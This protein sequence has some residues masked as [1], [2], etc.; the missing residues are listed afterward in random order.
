[1]PLGAPDAEPHKHAHDSAD[2]DSTAVSPPPHDQSDPTHSGAARRPPT[3]PPPPPPPPAPPPR[4]DPGTIP[5]PTPKRA[6]TPTQQP[7]PQRSRASRH[8]PGAL[9]GLLAAA[10]LAA[11]ALHAEP[12]DRSQVAARATARV[13]RHPPR[14]T[15]LSGALLLAAAARSLR[16]ATSSPAPAPGADHT[17][18]PPPRATAGRPGT[19]APV[20]HA[21][22]LTGALTASDVD[23]TTQAIIDHEITA[24]FDT[25]TAGHPQSGAIQAPMPHADGSDGATAHGTTHTIAVPPPNLR[26]SPSWMPSPPDSHRATTKRSPAPR[27][28]GLRSKR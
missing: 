11:L 22:A 18:P 23:A 7:L 8:R 21:T 10:A 9:T 19:P 25:A 20:D 16:K 15:L 3:T 4:P 5:A 2:A 14:L 6:P 28:S 1:M 26:T 27:S 12:P 13:P 24:T 17:T